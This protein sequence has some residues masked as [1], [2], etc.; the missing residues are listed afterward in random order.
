LFSRFLTLAGEN[1]RT[2]V[3]L[4]GLA[5]LASG[6]ATLSTAAAL[7]VPGAILVWL[8]IPPAARQRKPS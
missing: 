1:G 5:L 4:F 6:L 3:F 7:I 2:A 8:A